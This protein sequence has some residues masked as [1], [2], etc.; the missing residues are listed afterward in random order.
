MIKS[1]L[2]LSLFAIALVSC[3]PE[4]L[5]T[6]NQQGENK[7]PST[8]FLK[9]GIIMP[10]NP[11]NAY[12]NAGWMHNHILE[13]YTYSNPA[14]L[15]AR[16]TA[17]ESIALADSTFLYLEPNYTSVSTAQIIV[18][19]ENNLTQV[20]FNSPLSLSSQD[21]LKALIDTILDLE[22]NASSYEVVYDLIIA[23]ESRIIKNV[24]LPE[25]QRKII[26]TITSIAR[27]ASY[28]DKGK[29]KDKDWHLSKGSLTSALRGS[30]EGIGKAIIMSLAGG[31]Y[32]SGN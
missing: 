4:M 13:A 24:E 18:I 28:Y 25:A 2:W 22:A 10:A 15:R 30:Q 1:I 32:N 5:E 27:Y 19:T 23:Y 21:S 8:T 7:T 16:I 12:D 17:L 3:S 20:L 31:L 29:G 11:S 26:L 14:S 6:E 9:T